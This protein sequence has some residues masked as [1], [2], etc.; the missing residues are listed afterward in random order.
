M[1]TIDGEKHLNFVNDFVLQSY[2][3]NKMFQFF[4]DEL[5]E[6]LEELEQEEMDNKLLDNLKSDDLPAVPTTALPDVPTTCKLLFEFE[7]YEFQKKQ[8][9]S[10]TAERI[11]KL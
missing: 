4:Q 6:E 10:F 2:S 1:F 3:K 8:L 11:F 5:L 9:L 7:I